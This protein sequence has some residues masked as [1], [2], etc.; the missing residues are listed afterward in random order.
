MG[1]LII[2]ILAFL[3]IGISFLYQNLMLQQ[4]S[5]NENKKYF[6]Y[7]L[8]DLVSKRKG[9]NINLL[10]ISIISLFVGEFTEYIFT[11]Y[12]IILILLLIEGIL[13]FIKYNQ[14]LPLKFTKRMIRIILG[15][16][17]ITLA[18]FISAYFL[19]NIKYLASLIP[20]Y[21]LVLP[22]IIIFIIFLLK[23]VEKMIFNHY[24]KMALTKLN[25]MDNLKIIG[26]TGSFGKTST[27]MILNSILTTT[28]KGFYT[29]ASFNT[30]NGLLM[31]IN[32]E[33]SI[34][35]EYFISEMGAKKVGEIKELCDLVHPKYGILTSIGEAHLETFKSI[36]NI[37]KTKFELI[38]SLEE[39]GLGILNND[40]KYQREYKIKNK[41]NIIYVGIYNDADV[42]AKNIKV[43]SKGTSFD[44][45]FKKDKKSLSVSTIL[46]GE[47]NVYNI[48]A[49]CALA[50]AL[51]VSDKNIIKGVKNIKAINHRLELSHINNMTIL[52][53]SFNSN[54]VG[55]KNALDVLSLM[56]D[57]KIIITPGMIEMGDKEYELNYNFGR[58]IAK[59]CDKVYLVGKKQTKPIYEGLLKEKYKKEDIIINKSFKEAFDKVKVS[60]NNK[61]VVVL[62]ENDLPDSYTEDK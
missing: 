16:L 18:I 55:A 36:E 15:E 39:D 35:N 17:I 53:D 8:K 20:F 54:P 12:I 47:K 58:Q 9:L 57:T 11:F 22:F 45:Y 50:N 31:T 29:P 62:F 2:L 34:F 3:V 25:K 24:K 26:I 1:K 52:D 49:A 56:D 59:V 48:L 40:D 38:E 32:S 43:S 13:H 46:L 28:F 61:P 21:I 5:Y 51:G 23:P 41:V 6:S 27:K 4:N 30:P 44:V 14:K 60:F 33:K 19:L 10:I 7:A 42:M 37:Q